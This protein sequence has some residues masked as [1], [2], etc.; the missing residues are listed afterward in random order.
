MRFVRVEYVSSYRESASISLFCQAAHK[1]IQEEGRRR[2]INFGHNAAISVS[3][4]LSTLISRPVLSAKV[5]IR[6]S[7]V[8]RPAVAS[9]VDHSTR[10]IGAVIGRIYVYNINTSRVC[11]C[12]ERPCFSGRSVGPPS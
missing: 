7:K 9:L 12:V 6:P 5:Y 2:G 3:A 10:V 4:L 11:V 1:H 8:Y